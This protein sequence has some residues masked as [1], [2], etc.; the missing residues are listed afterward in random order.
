M[1]YFLL[2]SCLVFLQAQAMP[3]AALPTKPL[4]AKRVQTIIEGVEKVA[5]VFKSFTQEAKDDCIAMAQLHLAAPAP[6]SWKPA[7]VR[8]F[9]SSRPLN[10]VD[11]S[12]DAAE[13]NLPFECIIGDFYCINPNEEDD[14]PF[15]LARL[16]HKTKLGGKWYGRLRYLYTVNKKKK[17]DY[18][19]ATYYLKDRVTPSADLKDKVP[20][21]D[22]IMPVSMTKQ[23]G[24]D[25]KTHGQ[26][27]TIDK[28]GKLKRRLTSWATR[29]RGLLALCFLIVFSSIICV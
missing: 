17:Q 16:A 26:L 11:A 18:L 14:S 10:V 8:T 20:L 24:G 2:L 28:R 25:K 13:T 12:P 6:F 4:D 15:W 21:D 22:L 19:E 27:Y 29:F 5:S 7:R 3:H 23:S 1:F 9:F